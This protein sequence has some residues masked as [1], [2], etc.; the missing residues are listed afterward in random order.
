MAFAYIDLFP[1]ESPRGVSPMA[2]GGIGQHF[3][4]WSNR[5]VCTLLYAPREF[6]PELWA[7]LTAEQPMGYSTMFIL[8]K[9][10]ECGRAGNRRPSD[11]EIRM[12]RHAAE[13]QPAPAKYCAFIDPAYVNV[14]GGALCER[15]PRAE[16]AYDDARAIVREHSKVR[17]LTCRVVS[18]ES[19]H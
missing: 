5:N 12:A 16:D 11:R 17:V 8:E 15:H 6:T 18:S 4:Y 9:V 19:W 2:P 14:G 7:R 3:M 10:G 1:Q 13:Q